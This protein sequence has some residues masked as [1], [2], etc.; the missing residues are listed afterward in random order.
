M[1]LV[2]R[3]SEFRLAR[4]DIFKFAS[5][6]IQVCIRADAYAAFARDKNL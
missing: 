3:E 6:L 4:A 1:I 5:D 2:Q